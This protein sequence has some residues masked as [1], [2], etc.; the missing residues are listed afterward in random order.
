[1]WQWEEEL[2]EECRN[3]LLDV[4]LFPS[5]SD[6]WVWLPDPSGAYTVHGAYNL[7][8][9]QDLSAPEPTVDLLWHPQ[10]PIKVSIFAWRL[11]RNRLPTKSNLVE[12]GILAHDLSFCA[13]GCGV[14]ESAQHLFL[15][16]NTFGSLWQMVRNW[17][18][19]SGVD[20]DNISDHFLQF[21]HLTGGGK[22]RQSFMQ[23]LWLLCAWVIWIERNNRVFQNV[24]TP[25]PR[26]LDKIKML[27]L[28]WLKA[29]NANF[30]FGTQQ[31]WSHPFVC[32]GIG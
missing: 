3:L 24:V 10:V 4:S 27:S 22:A 32:L 2:L 31:W 15:L 23:L 13:A 28:G 26:L 18:G 21:T 5:V 11:I 19:C 17:V 29:K 7:L 25:I 1:M 12:K 8:T 30:V 16:C 6:R 9:S 14:P 20:S